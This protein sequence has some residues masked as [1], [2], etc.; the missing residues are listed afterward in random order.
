MS[1]QGTPENPIYMKWIQSGDTTSKLIVVGLLS[2]APVAAAILMQQ[3]ALR[4]A[5][6]MR[7]WNLA[8]KTSVKQS[9]WWLELARKAERQYSLAKL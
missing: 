3:P 8:A 9:N 2:L 5:I 6:K 7:V 4:Q 1:E